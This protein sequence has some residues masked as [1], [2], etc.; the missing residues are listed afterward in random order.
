MSQIT[1]DLEARPHARASAR[2]ANRV[3]TSDVTPAS[4]ARSVSSNPA[5]YWG[6][7]KSLCHHLE[8]C[9]ADI[10]PGSSVAS[11]SRDRPQSSMM[12]RNEANADIGRSKSIVP[13]SLGQSVLKS[14]ADVSLD[15]EFARGQTVPMADQQTET[16]YKSAFI[17]RVKAARIARNFK[18]WQI[19]E[20]LGMPQD[21]Y[22]QY[23]SRSLLPHHLIGRFCII[24]HVDP[25][26]LLT[27]R[28]EKGLRPIEV[29]E[30]EKTAARPVVTRKKAKNVA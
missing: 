23:E 27:G 28:G 2:A 8:T 17:A 25:E 3:R 30:V 18:Q 20:A 11:A 13:I 29:V 19:A 9:V 4:R 7:I 5:Q 15:C 16:Q 14:K 21:K 26:W 22:K 10:W 12:L 24:T 1:N 6:G